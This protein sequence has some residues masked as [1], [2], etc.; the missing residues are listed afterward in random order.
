M[1]PRYWEL[2][3]GRPTVE[4]ML[5]KMQEREDAVTGTLLAR[6]DPDIA[7][8]V[9]NLKAASQM[10]RQYLS[11]VAESFENEKA[12]STHLEE[13]NVVLVRQA[14][15]TVLDEA[16]PRTPGLAWNFDDDEQRVDFADRVASFLPSARSA[17]RLSAEVLTLLREAA[18][19]LRF[20]EEAARD[21][22][23]FLSGA[24][25]HASLIEHFLRRY[26][27]GTTDGG[28]QHG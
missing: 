5:T 17:T 1:N 27:S 3:G 7:R 16:N 2:N 13:I 28:S 10:A 26:E 9:V 23:V 14:I 20:S 19:E 11:E 8:L 15:L 6:I 21:H 25:A 24:G 12:T 4:G 18:K 22:D